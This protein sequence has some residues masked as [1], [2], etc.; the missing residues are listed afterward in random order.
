MD[1]IDNLK[2][3]DIVFYG[4]QQLQVLKPHAEVE[5][6]KLAVYTDGTRVHSQDRRD[7]LRRCRPMTVKPGES[8]DFAGG[9][10]YTFLGCVD[11]RER[12]ARTMPVLFGGGELP[13]DKYRELCF[14]CLVSG[15]V[16]VYARLSDQLHGYVI[17]LTYSAIVSAQIAMPDLGDVS[18]FTKADLIAYVVL[19]NGEGKL[20]RDQI[21]EKVAALERKPWIRTS[22]SDYFKGVTA[23]DKGTIRHAAKGPR[24]RI[25]YGLGDEGYK[26]A[27]KVVARLGEVP[28][29]L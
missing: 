7:F 22:N 5:T 3:G 24:G 16:E 27:A 18:G 23:S 2:P 26:R 15:D 28:G 19:V 10:K 13:I 12:V 11:V 8:F 20:S 6:H 25:L 4:D 17:D 1:A 9:Q 14:R 29:R 21:M